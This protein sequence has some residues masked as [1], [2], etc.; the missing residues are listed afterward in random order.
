MRTEEQNC[1]DDFERP[2]Y[3]STKLA[4]HY[5]ALPD[6][7]LWSLTDSALIGEILITQ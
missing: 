5:L 4:E 6:Q 7:P 1:S 3:Y 2:G